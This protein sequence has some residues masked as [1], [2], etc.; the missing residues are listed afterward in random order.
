MQ[1]MKKYQE[2]ASRLL[3]PTPPD[4]RVTYPAVRWIEFLPC[5]KARYSQAQW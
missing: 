4:E 5:G 3:P 1:A 2:E